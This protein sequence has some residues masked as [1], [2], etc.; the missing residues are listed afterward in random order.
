M[1]LDSAYL[2]KYYVTEPDSLAVRKLIAEA[3]E[4]CSSTWAKIE[5][6]SVF[7]RQIREKWLSPSEGRELIDLFRS[8]V[9]AD[10][11]DLRPVTDALLNKTITFIPGLPSHVPVRAGSALHLA[12][13]LDAGETEL[14]TN[15]RHLLAAANHVGLIGKSVTAP[16]RS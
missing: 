7:Q 14:W 2:A 4:I 11:W 6:V 3:S 12:T 5:V 16:A 8:H 13:A 10:V 9:E 15:D 1:Y